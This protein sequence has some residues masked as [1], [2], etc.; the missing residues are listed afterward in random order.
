MFG[1]QTTGKTIERPANDLWENTFIGEIGRGLLVTA[2]HFFVNFFT[3]RWTATTKYPEQRVVYPPRYR[4]VH[5]L[6]R[7]EDG[8]VRCVACFC[9][10]TA[11][12]AECIHIEA[13]EYPE[14]DPRSAYEKYPVR[15]VIDEMRCVFC[16]YCE[17]ACP[18][19]A[20][21]LDTGMHVPAAL[22]R[23]ELIYDKETLQSFPGRDGT[24]ITSNPRG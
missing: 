10:A 16:G 20:I 5:R 12:P 24:F 17:E 6:L 22:A 18:C 11:C 1:K 4:G 13:G 14:D 23:T 19:D 2:K 9:C 3:R 8:S 15:F 7:R 21:R